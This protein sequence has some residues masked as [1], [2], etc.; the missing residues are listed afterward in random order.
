MS[1]S[2]YTS[3]HQRWAHLRFSVIGQLLAAPPPKGEL[4]TE[5]KKLAE[6]TWQH[7]ITGGPVRFAASTIERWLMRARR[8]FDVEAHPERLRRH[9]PDLGRTLGEALLE[10]HRCY[11]NMLKPHMA[12]VRGLAHITGGG[13]Y[14][15]IPRIFPSNIRA[16]IRKRTWAV[17]PLFEL[18]QR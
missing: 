1:A 9:E 6:R 17:P 11:Y 2:K 7:P 14:E 12:K 18:I 10:P 3:I 4:R 8:V 13:F 16:V 5:I 15:N